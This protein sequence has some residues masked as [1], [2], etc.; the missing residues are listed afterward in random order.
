MVFSPNS[1]PRATAQRDSEMWLQ[2]NE[3]SDFWEANEVTEAGGEE[4]KSKALYSWSSVEGG[5]TY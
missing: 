4:V 2:E 5:T 1:Y 3:V